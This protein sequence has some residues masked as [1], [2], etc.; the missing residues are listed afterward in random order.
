MKEPISKHNLTT[1]QL[2]GGGWYVDMWPY[3]SGDLSWAPCH[4]PF[5][6]LHFTSAF[7]SR[8]FIH[9]RTSIYDCLFSSRMLCVNIY[10][11]CVAILNTWQYVLRWF[12]FFFA[13]LRR[14]LPVIACLIRVNVDGQQ[15]V[16]RFPANH[17]LLR[18]MWLT[19]GATYYD[20][21]VAQNTISPATGYR[22]VGS[23]TTSLLALQ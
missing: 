23:L 1:G 22:L 6:S 18:D 20:A 5:H 11:F 2:C 9:I 17:L 19:G 8:K 4:L 21:M 16:S 14:Q 15:I 12:F 3:L 7:D 13:L 10:S